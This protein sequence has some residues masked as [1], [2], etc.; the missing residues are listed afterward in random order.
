MTLVIGSV[1][2]T[3]TRVQRPKEDDRRAQ[4]AFEMHQV[5]LQISEARQE[6]F[7]Q[8]ALNSYG[9]HAAR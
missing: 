7:R 5:E 8:M 4:R 2:L 1:Q 6:A 9:M 3:I